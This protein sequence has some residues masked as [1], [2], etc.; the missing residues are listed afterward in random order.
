MDIKLEEEIPY[1]KVSYIKLTRIISEILWNFNS[2][3]K[4]EFVK[5]TINKKYLSKK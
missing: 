5:I 2:K 3:K 1:S 4:R